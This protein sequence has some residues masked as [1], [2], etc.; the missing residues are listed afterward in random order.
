M[1]STTDGAGMRGSTPKGSDASGRNPRSR[2][3]AGLRLASGIGAGALAGCNA[4]EIATALSAWQ[5]ELIASLVIVV[6]GG[7]YL[8]GKYKAG[9]M[10]GKGDWRKDFDSTR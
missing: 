7:W 1:R 6:V 10:R 9:E 2:L 3:Y 8:W 4:S 5:W